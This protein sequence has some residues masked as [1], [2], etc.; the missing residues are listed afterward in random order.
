LHALEHYRE[1]SAFASIDRTIEKLRLAPIPMGRNDESPRYMV[2][3]CGAK[4]ASDKMEAQIKTRG[5]AGGSEDQTLVNIE[6][7]W[8][9]THIGVSILQR[10]RISPMGGRPLAI[11]QSGGSEYKGTRTN[12]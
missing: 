9:D 7:I 6:H 5:T 2:G 1:G 8:V 12:G 3:H 10:R 11:Q 4:I